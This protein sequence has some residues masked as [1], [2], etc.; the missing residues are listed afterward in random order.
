M[1]L[2]SEDMKKDSQESGMQIN[3]NYLVKK[4][5]KGHKNI[6]KVKDLVL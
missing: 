5:T 2:I 3:R 6:K 1:R 4:N